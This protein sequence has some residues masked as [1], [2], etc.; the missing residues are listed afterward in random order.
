MVKIPHWVIINEETMKC[1]C[2]ACGKE[3]YTAH[4]KIFMLRRSYGVCEECMDKI[5]GLIKD[6]CSKKGD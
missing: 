6:M 2:E 4:M 5:V 1:K 3:I